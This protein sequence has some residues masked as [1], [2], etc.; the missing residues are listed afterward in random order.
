[1]NFVVIDV[2]TANP[3][4]SSICQVGVVRFEG[5]RETASESVLVDPRSWFC[6]VHVGIHGIDEGRVAGA[7][8]FRELACWLDGWTRGQTVV[9]H[10]HFDR[11]A[12]AQAC[13]R[14][15]VPSPTCEW[16]DSAGVV[17][18]TWP[19]F[20]KT[21]YGLANVAL[22]LGIAFRHHDAVEDARAAGTILLRAIEVSG[23]PLHEWQYAVRR[24]IADPRIRMTGDGDGPLLGERIVFTGSLAIA[25]R[26]AAALAA[27]AG[28]DVEPGV[29][30]N[31]SMVVVGDQDVEKLNGKSKSA[32]HL[33]AEAL[34]AK[35]HAIRIVGEADFA[36]MIAA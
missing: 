32:K 8:C 21:G 20:A 6:P 9:C 26:E 34:I 11:V 28:A 7:P 17:R 13:R 27:E 12:V 25:R 18:R 22:H 16:L 2:E 30:L 19:E 1:M 33:K 14:N 10:T 24:P 35:G 36:A 5:G 23:R 29:T 4:M 3:Q 31:T 15:D